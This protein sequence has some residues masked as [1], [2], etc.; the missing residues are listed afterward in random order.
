MTFAGGCTNEHPRGGVG[1]GRPG[2]GRVLRRVSAARKVCTFGM[3]TSVESIAYLPPYSSPDSRDAELAA[4]LWR[5]SEEILELNVEGLMDDDGSD[6]DCR[7]QM[8]ANGEI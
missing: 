2:Y 6:C 3:R 1:G 8:E 4:D 5:R 7:H